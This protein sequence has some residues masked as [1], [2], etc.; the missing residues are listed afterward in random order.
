MAKKSGHKG[1]IYQRGDGKWEAK[2]SL[3]TNHGTG[4]R[5]RKSIYAD[6]Q[7]EI[8]EQLNK[9]LGQGYAGY[10]IDPK[11]I[12]FGAWIDKWLEDYSK[13]F[14]V[15]NTYEGYEAFSRLYIKPLLG[16]YQLN[17]LTTND[18]QKTYNFLLKR[19][20]KKKKGLSAKTIWNIHTVVRA[21]L[22]QAQI[23]D[24]II[25]NPII[26]LKLPPKKKPENN[27]LTSE[28]MAKYLESIRAHRL[29]A[30]FVL[31]C[32]TGMRRG[33][34]LGLKW[35]CVNFKTGELK[36][37]ETWIKS[38]SGKTYFSGPKNETSKRTIII[39]QEVVKE[40]KKHKKAQAAEKLT[41]G[42]DYQKH[43]LIFPKENGEP[44]RPD[45]F[46]ETHIKLI[47]EAGLGHIRF[48]DLR[49]SVASALIDKGFNLKDIAELLGH[50]SIEVTADIYGHL[51]RERK[52]DATQSLVSLIPIKEVV[53]R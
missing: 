10:D 30:A 44:M 31:E 21:S 28:Q 27:Y 12:K 18:I 17:K 7:E 16:E 50:S 6:S 2:I 53:K 51:T 23:E 43:N 46:Y 13:P 20:G 19:G 32:V 39:P 45:T 11:Q 40:L 47:G 22:N 52:R 9:L 36:V 34:I 1:T 49:H 29:Y 37:K 14:V 25:R 3:G 4:K 33:E 42:D 8:Q 26:G 38:V 35:N 48:H 24:L 5:R 41:W 15:Q